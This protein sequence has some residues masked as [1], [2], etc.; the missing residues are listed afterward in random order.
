[1]EEIMPDLN[2]IGSQITTN[3]CVFKVVGHITN[4]QGKLVEDVVYVG[5]A[6]GINT[7]PVRTISQPKAVKQPRAAKQKFPRRMQ[8]GENAYLNLSRSGVSLSLQIAPGLCITTGGS[9]GTRMNV[10]MGPLRFSKSLGKKAKKKK[11]R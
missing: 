4:A 1:M 7:A 9:K 6:G 5:P 3:G 11:K 8:V 2:P 10:N